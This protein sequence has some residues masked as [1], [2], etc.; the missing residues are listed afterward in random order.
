M[1]LTRYDALALFKE[2][3]VVSEVRGLVAARTGCDTPKRT[4]FMQN[5]IQQRI[6]AIKGNEGYL[7]NSI[8]KKKKRYGW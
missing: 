8:K 2:I 1:L 3:Q 7:T 6:G 5:I 4:Y